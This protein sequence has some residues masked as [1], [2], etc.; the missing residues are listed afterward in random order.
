MHRRPFAW[1]V[2]VSLA[3]ASPALAGSYRPR[4]PDPEDCETL[5]PASAI[6]ARAR[7]TQDR[8]SVV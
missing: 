4:V 1:L 2:V 6:L 5:E 8:K 3:V 7:A